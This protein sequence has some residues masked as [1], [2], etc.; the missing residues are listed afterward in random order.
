MH[1]NDLKKWAAENESI[2]RT[3]F[4]SMAYAQLTRERVDAIERAI[5]AEKPL[6]NGMEHIHKGEL[7]TDPKLTYLCTDEAACAEYFAECD[8]RERAAGVKP[9]DMPTSHCPAL[10]AEDLQR[11]AEWCIIQSSAELF[12]IDPDMINTGL[13]T[14]AKWLDLILGACAKDM[15]ESRAA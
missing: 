14:R 6:I 11:Q 8:R 1:V 7:I 5:L 10:V 4:L 15:K 13:E 9:A 12:G 2:A 3:V